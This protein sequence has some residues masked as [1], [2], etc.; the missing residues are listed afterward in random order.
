[1]K[2]PNDTKD[3]AL[4]VRDAD[5]GQPAESAM[6]LGVSGIRTVEHV[7]SDGSI[8]RLSHRGGYPIYET[9]D[10]GSGAQDAET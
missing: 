1:M 8:M 9:V 10:G 2:W 7:Q 4:P 5:A 3:F 6:R